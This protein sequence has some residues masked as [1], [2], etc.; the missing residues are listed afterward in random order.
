MKRG[1]PVGEVAWRELRELAERSAR[2]PQQSRWLFSPEALPAVDRGAVGARLKEPV[3]PTSLTTR[4]LPNL[5]G[6]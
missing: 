5:R 6:K 2:S 4:V 3:D 1:I